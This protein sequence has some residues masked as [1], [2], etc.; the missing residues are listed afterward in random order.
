MSLI[1]KSIIIG[2]MKN[3]CYIQWMSLDWM[4]SCLNWLKV[5]ELKC[6]QVW[7]GHWEFQDSVGLFQNYIQLIFMYHYCVIL[8]DYGII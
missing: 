7:G 5:I 1:N 4:G 6:L 8:I 3:L 2:G